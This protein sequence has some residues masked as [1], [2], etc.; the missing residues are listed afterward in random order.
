[1]PILNDKIAKNNDKI[2][3]LERERK[4]LLRKNK[5]EVKKINRL[6]IFIVGELFCRYF[7][8]ITSLVPGTK[9]QNKEIFKEFES[10]LSVLSSDKDLCGYIQEKM[11]EDYYQNATS[12]GEKT[13]IIENIDFSNKNEENTHG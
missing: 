1:M 7:P 2:A 9:E 5:E 8:Q 13:T 4:E 3:Q 12:K 10:F 11:N 6:R